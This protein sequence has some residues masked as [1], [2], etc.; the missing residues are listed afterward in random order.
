MQLEQFKKLIAEVTA[1]IGNRPLTN[2]LERDLNAAFPAQ[3]AH[4]RELLSACRS[5]S[6]AGVMCNREAGGIKFGRIVKPGIET[7]GFSVDVV[8][9][10]DIAGPHHR[11]PNGEI[12]LIMPLSADAKFDGRGAGWL[13][14]GPGT[15]HSP[16][17]SQGRALVLYLLP[18]GSIEF[19]KT[20][21]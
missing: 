5:G 7:G 14:Y 18:E 12:D 2:E 6:A 9:M 16:T 8:D 3:G 15:S 4:F 21:R 10:N 19:T 13:V 20:S 1:F 17:V 11:H